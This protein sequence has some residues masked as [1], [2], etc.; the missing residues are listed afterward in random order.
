MRSRVLEWLSPSDYEP[1]QA[2]LSS[3]RQAG[4]GEWFLSSKKFSDWVNLL[5]TSRPLKTISV[6]FEG[7]TV[8]EVRASEDDL[9]LYIEAMLPRLLRSCKFEDDSSLRQRIRE[10]LIS[11]S[12]GM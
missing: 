9:I 1:L 4:S 10:E 5:A 12:Q 11:A 2:D 8:Q 3:R 6:R 7:A